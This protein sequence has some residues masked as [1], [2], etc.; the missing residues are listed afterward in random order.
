MPTPNEHKLKLALA[1][2]LP[3]KIEYRVGGDCELPDDTV[4]FFWVNLY[5]IRDT[6]WL[7]ICWL[8]EQMLTGEECLR[9]AD[10]LNRATK[11]FKH[12]TPVIMCIAPWPQRAQALAKVKGVE[13]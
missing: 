3:E 12:I 6:E 13:V 10:E 5:E 1:G 8:V 11:C 7:H 2:M 4:F 9:Y